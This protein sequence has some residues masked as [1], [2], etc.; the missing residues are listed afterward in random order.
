M[1][2]CEEE[3]KVVLYKLANAEELEGRGEASYSGGRKLEMSI[4]L[5]LL[6]IL[7]AVVG[8][9]SACCYSFLS[10]STQASRTS[11]AESALLWY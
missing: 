1:R 5:T 6:G 2:S 7:S 4:R 8:G 11:S 3:Q 10:C 9:S